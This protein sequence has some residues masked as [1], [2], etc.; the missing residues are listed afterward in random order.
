MKRPTGKEKSQE[1]LPGGEDINAKLLT[2][3]GQ[4]ISDALLPS[5]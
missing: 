3:N 5:L 1:S 2:R 4:E